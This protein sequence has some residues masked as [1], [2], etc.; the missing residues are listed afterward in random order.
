MRD[1]RV[2]AYIAKGQPFAQEILNHMREL[3]HLACPEVEETIKWGMPFFQL[4]GVILANM[5]GFK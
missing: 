2:D 3:M 1:T 4:N 5:A